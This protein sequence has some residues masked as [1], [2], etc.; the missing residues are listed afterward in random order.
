MMTANQNCRRLFTKFIFSSLLTVLFTFSV[1]AQT[2]SGAIEGTVADNTGALIPAASVR[3]R[4][5]TTGVMRTV[6]SDEQG[7]FRAASLPIGKYEVSVE[8]SGFAPYV[9]AEVPL[10]IGQTVRLTV[11]LTAGGVEEKVTI[12][13]TPPPLDATQTTVTTNII[14]EQIE[15]LPV[16]SRNYREDTIHY[17]AQGHVRLGNGFYT[18]FEGP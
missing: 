3:L 4:H 11:T 5:K 17:D 6:Q 14:H 18:L 13:D 7:F 2:S 8:Q 1:H 12:T 16:R 9:Y 10:S 15:E